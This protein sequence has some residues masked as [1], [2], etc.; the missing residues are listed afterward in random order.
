MSDVLRVSKRRGEKVLSGDTFRGCQD[1]RLGSSL[2]WRPCLQVG[3]FRVLWGES[4]VSYCFLY[5]GFLHWFLAL[6][7]GDSRT[8]F[9]AFAFLRFSLFH[10]GRL[11]RSKRGEGGD[12][13]DR[14]MDMRIGEVL[15]LLRGLGL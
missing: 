10:W 9:Y 2:S 15:Q 4:K 5:S 1:E 13:K 7:R 14:A 12:N 3:A 8:A 11:E 6:W